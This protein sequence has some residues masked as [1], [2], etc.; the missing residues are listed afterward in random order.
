[1]P[2]AV[3]ART[4]PAPGVSGTGV[5]GIGPLADDGGARHNTHPLP[6]WGGFRGKVRPIMQCRLQIPAGRTV[7]AAAAAAATAMLAA[8]LAAAQQAPIDIVAAA[9][10]DRGHTCDDPHS[11]RREDGPRLTEVWLLTCE[12]G[13]HYRVVFSTT[14]HGD[15]R[16]EA[17]D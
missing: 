7:R 2:G 9:V 15:Y 11:V 8:G 4:A 6:P 13:Q 16:V 12:A 17:V 14:D 10:R 3:R 1:M 5:S